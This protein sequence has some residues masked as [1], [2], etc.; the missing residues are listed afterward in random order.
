[1]ADDF[2]LTTRTLLGAAACGGARDTAAAFAPDADVAVS[3]P[4]GV[5]QGADAVEAGLLAPLRTALD[6]CHRRDSIV[7]GAPNRRAEGGTWVATVTAYVGNFVQ[8]LWGIA[9]SGRVVFLRAGEFHRVED[10]RIT[11][12]RI[13]IDLPELMRQ[14]GRSP[15][16][17]EQGNDGIFPPPATGDGVAPSAANGAASLDRVEAML[18]DLHDFDPMTGTSPNQ[19]G[20]GGHWHDSMLWYGPCGIGANYRW[21]G[22]VKDHRRH[23]LGA[24]PDRAGGNH[25]C[26]IGDGDY[27]AVSGW[28]SIT[29]THRGRYLGVE[30]TNRVLTMRVMDFYRLSA[31]RIAENWVFLDLV[32]LFAQMGV[33]IL[34][35]GHGDG[36]RSKET[37]SPGT[38]FHQE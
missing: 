22:F 28:P 34:P 1:M 7:I 21:D 36:T 16:P 8:P 35:Q 18:A 5:L 26:R 17:P 10:G 29:M 24:F 9:P 27:A 37:A 11:R 13:I 31:G 4:V 33:D 23:F 15:F 38:P 32:D 12:S 14:E 19:T 6:G 2:R 30:P 20:E 3:A 25:Y